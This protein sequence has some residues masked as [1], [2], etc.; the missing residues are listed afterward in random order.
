MD[1]TPRFRSPRSWPWALAILL[2]IIV[3]IALL[4]YKRGECVD[5]TIE[6]GATSMCTSG[7][8]LSMDGTWILAV[9]GVAAVAYFTRRLVQAVRARRT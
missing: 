1:E 5:Y 3:N 4:G 6:S 8:A 7:P 2:V 9:L